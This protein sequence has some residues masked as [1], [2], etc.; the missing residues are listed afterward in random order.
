[1]SYRG[2][3]GGGG[4]GGRGGFDRGRGGGGGGD[5]GGYRG[6]GGPGGDR[7]GFRGGDRGR[8]GPPFR[9]G[10]PGG[11]EP[12]GVFSAPD[13]ASDFD[14]RLGGTDQDNL[15]NAFRS[16]SLKHD[17]LPLRP[18]WGKSG[19]AIKLRSNF[20]AVK[21]PKGPLCEYD[22]KIT[23]AVTVRRVKRRIFE[24]LEQA[25]EYARFRTGVAHDF[26]AK[27]VAARRLPQPLTFDI[28]YFDEGEKGPKE[29]GKTYAVEITFIQDID[30][31]MLT[32]YLSGNS[33]YRDLDV[34]PVLAALN[35]VLAQHPTRSGVMLMVN[36]NVATTAFYSE[37]NLANAMMEFRNASFGARIDQFIRGVRISTTHLGHRKTVKKAA[38]LTARSHRF[39]WDEVNRQVSVE[40]YFQIKYKLRL[41]HPDMPLIDV[42]GQKSNLLPAEVCQILPGQPF[43]G[44]LTDEHTAQMIL[45]AC[46]PPNVNAR[47]IVGP[48]LQSLVRWPS[49]PGR[50]LSSPR[51]MYNQKS[52]E[53]DQRASWNLRNVR[54]S[55]GAV[56][57]K[58]AVLLIRDGN[59]RAEF[60]S[61]DDP[62]LQKTIAG[63]SKMCVTSG[64]TVR[65]Q[66]RYI[67]AQLPPKN[68]D[69]PTRKAA[70]ATIR[71]SI[72]S[73]KPKVDLLMVILSNGDKHIYSGIKHLCDVYLDVH[74]VCVH[75]EKIRKDKGQ[76]QYFANVALKFNMKLGGVNHSL[77]PESMQ[78]LKQA[79]TMLVGM[80]VTHP[81]PGSLKG[82]PSIAAVVA[83]VDEHYAQFPASLRIQETRKEMIT[84]LK[85]MMI[86]RLDT[87]RERSKNALPQRVLVYRDG[88]SEGQY[89]TVVKEEMPAII[90]AFRK[91]DQPGRPY[92]P[93]LSI[94]VCG[95]RH[96]T[97]FYP[98]D[99]GNADQLGN[100]RPGTVVDQGV[101]GVF[102][103]DFFLQ[104]HGGLQ[105]TTR[106]T[107]Y[108]VVH[109][110]IVFGAD[111]LQKLTNDVSYLFARATKAVSLVSPAY[112]ADLACERGRC[113]IH[114][115]LQAVETTT[116]SS[117][118]EDQVM[119]SAESL[120][121]NGVQGPMLRG[122]MFYL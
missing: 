103:F 110:E 74:T 70:I 93:K 34:A 51:V 54:F 28:A 104:A 43:R 99:A 39:M 67:Q 2:D 61:T 68:R 117:T 98:T 14:A 32:S 60:Q 116:A 57:E 4:R 69:D 31:S 88:V 35:I 20:F 53:V 15:V 83:S 90:E 92:R 66:P 47:S 108:Y 114:E 6:R 112:Y 19:T 87:F 42:G 3:R 80:D 17:D 52:Q 89:T 33:E 79:P 111:Q 62:E 94:V 21:M 86:E 122:T 55:R 9:G 120:W 30:L 13:Q 38:Q 72:T 50:I 78:W 109:D 115:L 97:R 73:L 76:L 45:H 96:H 10:A 25:T 95:K 100:P 119:R 22:V 5:R 63:F 64:M 29:N 27:L 106:P 81:G 101:T 11:R 56:L 23:P 48:G 77:D 8:G 46:K 71:T 58:W 118:A 26:G 102:A 40:E 82:T 107:H 113:Y 49:S 105:G 65:G 1:M 18:G 36:V 41:Q 59:A 85:E 24:L 121:R 84:S 7:G 75:S 12:G 44:K 16:I 91:Y 37:G